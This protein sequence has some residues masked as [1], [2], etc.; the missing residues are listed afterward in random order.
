MCI[1]AEHDMCVI[2][3]EQAIVMCVWCGYQL[4]EDVRWNCDILCCNC[5]ATDDEWAQQ[6]HKRFLI[7]V[8]Q[9]LRA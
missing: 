5:M 9:S 4:V 8:Q 7:N 6:K 1:D 2:L 3:C